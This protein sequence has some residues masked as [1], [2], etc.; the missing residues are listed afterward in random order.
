VIADSWC[1]WLAITDGLAT[2]YILPTVLGIARQ[3]ESLGMVICLNAIP[4][5][6]PAALILACMMPSKQSRRARPAP[7]SGY[8]RPPSRC[9]TKGRQAASGLPL[10]TWVACQDTCPDA[11]RAV[12]GRG[13]SLRPCKS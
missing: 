10:K 8:G 9:W 2:V 7:A 11:G 4:V 5:G 3:G 12:P 1:V 13:D 6:W